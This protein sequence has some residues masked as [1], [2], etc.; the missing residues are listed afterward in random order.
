MIMV[1]FILFL[2]SLLYAVSINL[3]I[4]PAGLFSGGILG[5][6]QIVRTIVANLFEINFGFDISGLIALVINISLLLLTIKHNGNKFALM[7]VF[8]VALQSTLLSVIPITML[9]NDTLTAVIIGGILC[10]I[11]MG[12]LLKYGGSS[13]GVDIIGVYLTRKT[14]FSVGKINLFVDIAVYA[15]AFI[16][17]RNTE[18]IIYSI[19]FAVVCVATIDRTHSQN[20]NCEIIIISKTKYYEIKQLILNQ[21][22]RG[23]SYWQGN[24]GYSDDSNKI[25]YVITSKYELSQIKSKILL[26][27]PAAFISIKYNISIIGNFEKRI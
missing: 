17:I 7:T 9:I 2:S 21:L 27:D 25:I 5:I 13:G 14:E 8:C 16:L 26:I 1:Y 15:L 4:V 24:G 19:I 23:F 3:F 6:A 18:R 10:G 20:I 11:S 22:N 12:T